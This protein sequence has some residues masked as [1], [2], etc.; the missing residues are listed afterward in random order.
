MWP[1]MTVLYYRLALREEKEMFQ[2]FGEAYIDYK[3]RA[4]MFFP[5]IFQ[6]KKINTN[7]NLKKQMN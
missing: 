2:Q 3:L 7:M 4:G 1:I 5:V 6:T